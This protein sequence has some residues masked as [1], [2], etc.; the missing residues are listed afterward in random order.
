MA[1]HGFIFCSALASF[2]TVL[3]PAAPT[4]EAPFQDCESSLPRD[5]TLG[6]FWPCGKELS[7]VVSRLGGANAIPGP[8]RAHLALNLLMRPWR[9]RDHRWIFNRRIS[10]LD[11]TR[12]ST[13]GGVDVRLATTALRPRRGRFGAW[14]FPQ[15]LRTLNLTDA[16]LDELSVIPLSQMLQPRQDRDGSWRFNAMENLHIHGA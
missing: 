11:I 16:N 14:T 15:A 9:T 12:S 10:S 5:S 7:Y 2:L 13:I 8:A 3:Q 6:A 4:I 1:P